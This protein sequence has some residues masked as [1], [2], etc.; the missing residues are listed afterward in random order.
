MDEKKEK[1]GVWFHPSTIEKA[2]KV[3][4]FDNCKSRSAFIEKAV[5]FYAGYVLAQ[6]QEEYLPEVIISTFQ[7]TLD[8]LENRMASLLFK[9]AVELSM[10]LH[11]SAAHFRVDE[12]TLHRLRGRC[13]NDVKKLNGKI[14]FDDILKFQRGE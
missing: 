1:Y 14:T 12:D 6:E 11:V 9:Y 10:L 2:D 7:G 13:I 8:S 5:N 3:Y 4:P